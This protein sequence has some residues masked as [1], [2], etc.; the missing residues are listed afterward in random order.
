[1]VKYGLIE[2]YSS[3]ACFHSTFIAIVTA[4]FKSLFFCYMM[5]IDW[6]NFFQLVHC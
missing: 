1:M 6:H 4:N 2:I 5:Q 3:D